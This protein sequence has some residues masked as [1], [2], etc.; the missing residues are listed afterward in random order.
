MGNQ[1]RK[2]DLETPLKKE[3]FDTVKFSADEHEQGVSMT[4]DILGSNGELNQVSFGDYFP[5]QAVG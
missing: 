2:I 5:M 1:Y 4:W 3:V